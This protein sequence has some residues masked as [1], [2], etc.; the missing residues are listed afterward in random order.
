[1]GESVGAGAARNRGVAAAR[2]DLVAFLDGDDL[3]TPDHLATL[4][5]LLERICP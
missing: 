1:L 4:I 5:P 3:W 2:T